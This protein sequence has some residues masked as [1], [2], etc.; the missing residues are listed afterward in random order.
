[1]YRTF[2]RDWVPVDAGAGTKTNDITDN[3]QKYEDN[4]SNLMWIRG[5]VNKQFID[6][7]LDSGASISCI[8][9]R[10]VTASSSLRNFQR[11]QYQGPGLID[12]NGN[13]LAAAY[14]I[15]VP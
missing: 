5:E 2:K 6:M 12:V 3:N 4:C 10:C 9:E 11:K 7:L 13:P 1:M 8:A 15:R 14:E